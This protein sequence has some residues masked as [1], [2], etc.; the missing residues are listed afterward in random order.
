MDGETVIEIPMETAM[1]EQVEALYREMGI[2]FTTAVRIFAA[3]S[4]LVRG[5]P[6]QPTTVKPFQPSNVSVSD[7]AGSLR[8][9][10]LPGL[11]VKDNEKDDL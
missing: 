7:L 8:K 1:K 4:L 9:Y 5:M 2:D 3:Q 10:A 6:F 11:L